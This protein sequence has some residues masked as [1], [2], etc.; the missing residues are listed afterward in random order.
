MLW[1]S[2]TPRCGRWLCV[3]ERRVTLA[4]DSPG[5]LIQRRLFTACGIAFRSNQQPARVM[6]WGFTT[7]C[8]AGAMAVRDP[9]QRD[10]PSDSPK[11]NVGEQSRVLHVPMAGATEQALEETAYAA[12]LFS[13]FGDVT[14]ALIVQLLMVQPRNVSDLA[15]ATGIT[16]PTVSH[17]LHALA[18]RGLVVRTRMGRDVFYRLDEQRLGRELKASLHTLGVNGLG[19]DTRPILLGSAL[20]LTGCDAAN[21]LEAKRS[22]GLAVEEWNAQGGIRGRRIENVIVDIGNDSPTRCRKAFETL[23]E[24]YRVDAIVTGYIMS[25]GDEHELVTSTS[26]PYIHLNTSYF[27]RTL[28]AASPQTY[29]MC[30]QCDPS[31][32]VYALGFPRFLS[33]LEQQ[34]YR[35]KNRTV[36]IV[37]PSDP[38]SSALIDMLHRALRSYG[39]TAQV[40]DTIQAPCEHWDPV[41]RRLSTVRPDVIFL[42]DHLLEDALGFSQCF[43]KSPFPSLVYCHF[44]PTLPAFAESLGSQGEGILTSTTGGLIPGPLKDQYVEAFTARWGEPPGASLGGA[45]YDAAN[46]YLMAAAMSD[47]PSDARAVCQRLESLW[48]RGT[49]GVHRFPQGHA[50]PGYPIETNDPASGMPYLVFQVQHGR[51]AIIWPP[52]YAEGQFEPPAWLDG[53]SWRPATPA[54]RSTVRS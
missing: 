50:V 2:D 21:G 19:H 29:W 7:A 13:L 39:W 12:S 22:V 46:L 30:F 48:V 52:P 51:T 44:A 37:G 49:T 5:G 9:S 28:Y 8:G 47:S 38:Y 26:T 18:S 31:N 41:V 42:C 43:L 40:H 10:E 11:R 14:R 33:M 20:P 24:E 1:L 36:A 45:L 15:A 4:V 54:S 34:G 23:I 25:T 32:N 53:A 27:N 6:T 35:P 3:E 16:P 17:H